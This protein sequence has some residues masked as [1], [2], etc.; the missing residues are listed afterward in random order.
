MLNLPMWRCAMSQNVFRVI[1]DKWPT[2]DG[3]PFDEQDIDW[4]ERPDW[5]PETAPLDEWY[6]SGGHHYQDGRDMG[7]DWEETI[8]PSWRRW[9]WWS[10]SSAYKRVRELKLYG[11]KAHIETGTVNWK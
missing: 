1:V 2:P 8:A 11:V 7:P 5:M 10:K 4:C 9:K 6:R 3:M